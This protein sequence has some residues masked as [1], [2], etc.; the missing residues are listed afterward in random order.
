MAGCSRTRL[1]SILTI[2]GLYFT[3]S[4]PA[5]VFAQKRL[6]FEVPPALAIL[7]VLLMNAFAGQLGHV[8]LRVGDVIAGILLIRCPVAI[9]TFL[10]FAR[11]TS[12][13]EAIAVGSVCIVMA[14]LSWV[15]GRAMHYI[16]AGT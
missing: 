15:A 10:G 4:R 7:G 12:I 2:S 13:A 6:L 5:N 1:N 8:L 14:G 3:G 16:V 9:F 11:M